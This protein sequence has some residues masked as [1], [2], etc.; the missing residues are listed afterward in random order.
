MAFRAADVLAVAG[1]LTAAPMSILAIRIGDALH[2]AVQ[3][4]HNADPR[5]HR[6][7]IL[8]RHQGQRSHRRLP[9]CSFVFRGP[10]PCRA[11]SA[12]TALG[13]TYCPAAPAVKRPACR[14]GGSTTTPSQT[15]RS[16]ACP[17]TLDRATLNSSVSYLGSL[18]PGLRSSNS[19]RP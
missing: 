10:Q 16:T 12:G 6:R 7:T 8:F 14:F 3:G 4:S 9:F 17:L 18:S 15:I 1:Q 13:P 2:V 19:L 11:T 5:E